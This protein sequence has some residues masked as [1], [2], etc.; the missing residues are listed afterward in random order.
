MIVEAWTRGEI[1]ILDPGETLYSGDRLALRVEVDQ[2]AYV[3]A[4]YADSKGQV[5]QIFPRQGHVRIDPGRPYRIPPVGQWLKLDSEAGQENLFVVAQTEPMSAEQVAGRVREELRQAP[6][7]P[8]KK[9]RPVRLKAPAEERPAPPAIPGALSMTTRG[10]DQQ[11]TVR[12][13]AIEQGTEARLEKARA[14]L[15]RFSFQHK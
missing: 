14:A 11:G 12:G 6:P 15:I 4:L 1:H 7:P 3:Y 10:L 9:R 13:L 5:N 2:P 8:R